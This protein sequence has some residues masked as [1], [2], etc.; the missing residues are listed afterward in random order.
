MW[1]L[2]SVVRMAV[3]PNR[4]LSY[5]IS[6]RALCFLSCRTGPYCASS[7]PGPVRLMT[8]RSALVGG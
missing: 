3:A 7:R 8:L 2:G 1:P 4:A 5:Q 6:C